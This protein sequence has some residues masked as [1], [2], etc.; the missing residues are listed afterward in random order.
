VLYIR[1]VIR[2]IGP[3]AEPKR[4]CENQRCNR[5]L[6]ATLRSGA[7]FCSSSCRSKRHRWVTEGRAR[8][9]GRA[10]RICQ[11]CHGPITSYPGLDERRADARYCSGACRVAAYR[12]RRA[13]QEPEK[14]EPLRP[15]PQ[16]VDLSSFE[17]ILA[18]LRKAGCSEGYAT[19]LLGRIDLNGSDE[20]IFDRA[21]TV[22]I[23]E[24]LSSS[25][26]GP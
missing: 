11:E 10:K 1:S 26:A 6:P 2:Y 23:R 22:M 5:K 20:M 3:V 18:R 16:I 7:R 19:G 9:F 13:S 4:Y 15:S 24:T 12:R 17:P 25:L 21:I 8:T 14:E